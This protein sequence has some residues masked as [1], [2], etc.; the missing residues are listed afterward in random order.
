MIARLLS[1]STVSTRF[2]ANQLPEA[3]HGS[4]LWKIVTPVVN[5]ESMIPT[6]QQGDGLELEPADNLHVG[7]VVVYRHDRL[8]ICHRI[9]RIEGHRVFLRGDANVGAFEEAD[10]RHVMG[11]VTCLVRRGT[12]I[13]VGPYSRATVGRVGRDSTWV[14]ASTWGLESGRRFALRFLNSV[15]SLPG[16]DSMVRRLLRKLMT[17][18]IMER[19]SLQS[20]E[21]Y[22]ARQ[23]VH[24][25]QLA[26][27]RQ[28]LSPLKK[29]DIMFVIHAGPVYLG[30]CTL[31]P[32]RFYMRPLLQ[33]ITTEIL[34]ES[35][36][37]FLPVK[38][39]RHP[40]RRSTIIGMQ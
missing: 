39:P 37:L 3:V 22:V 9:H 40:A 38:T 32:W 20:L 4:A 15:A 23:R 33:S 16:V 13:A 25:D 30:T 24:L 28:Y 18:E 26:Y 27:C 12:R 36:G 29:N 11:R 35:I 1:P 5:S 17:I 6:L 21:G 2:S 31:N 10:V 34:S 14:R 19:A 7:D 8:F